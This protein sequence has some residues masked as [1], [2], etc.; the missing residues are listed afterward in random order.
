MQAENYIIARIEQ[1][2]EKKKISRYRL[3]QKSGIAQSSISTLLNRK[4]VPTIQTLEKICEG[5]DITLAQFFAG[6][7]E[8]PDLIADQKQLLS[9]WN[10]MDEHQ[11]ELVKAYIQGIIRK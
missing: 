9:D 8:I 11:K 5:F 2:C 1:L 6:D 7:E 3:A 10:E 4:S